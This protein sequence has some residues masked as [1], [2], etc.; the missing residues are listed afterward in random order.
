LGKFGIV[1]MCG[2]SQNQCDYLN[3]LAPEHGH[4]WWSQ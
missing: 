2:A 1:S 4:N 3:L